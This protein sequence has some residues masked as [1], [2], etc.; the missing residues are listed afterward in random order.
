M[1]Y[2]HGR[3][4]TSQVELPRSQPL[5]VLSFDFPKE[6]N[7]RKGIPGRETVHARVWMLTL[8]GTVVNESRLVYLGHKKQ[9]MRR[10]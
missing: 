2:T 4:D 5:T 7:R 8:C 9:G 1:D 6:A 10:E 3:R